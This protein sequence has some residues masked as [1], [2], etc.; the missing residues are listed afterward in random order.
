[1][2]CLFRGQFFSHSTFHLYALKVWIRHA[3]PQQGLWHVTRI[4]DGTLPLYFD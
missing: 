4:I 1:M 3:L 2:G